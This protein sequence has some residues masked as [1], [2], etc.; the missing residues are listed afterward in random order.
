MEYVAIVIVLLVLQY[1]WFGFKVGQA[2][3]KTE[4]SAPRMDGPEAFMRANRVHQ[5]TGEML[6][7]LIPAMLVFAHYTH[8]LAAAIGG[9]IFLLS[10]FWY[11]SAYRNNPSSRGAAF[12]I[13]FAA[14][15]IMAIG[16]LVGI[17]MTVI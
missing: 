5:N 8:A 9:A 11:D 12:I 17:V 10:R 16:G 6:I 2:R 4:T 15:A 3:V 14:F 13:G 7:A 1:A